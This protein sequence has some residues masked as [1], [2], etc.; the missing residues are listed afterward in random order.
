[1]RII[2]DKSIEIDGHIIECS[3]S[4]IINDAITQYAD[5]L[6]E[7]AITESL[8]CSG[9]IVRRCAHC[10]DVLPLELL[11]RNSYGDYLCPQCYEENAKR[12]ADIDDTERSDNNYYGRC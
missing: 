12:D 8:L 7:D 1:M 2:N 10:A 11:R 5:M 4:E 3:V 9:E 6:I